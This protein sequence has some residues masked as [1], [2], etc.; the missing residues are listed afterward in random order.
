MSS[1]DRERY[2]WIKLRTDYFE[3]DNIKVLESMDKG[4]A[5]LIFYLK[6]LLKGANCEGML[7]LSDTIPYDARLLATVTNTDIDTVTNALSKLNSL[8]MI[9]LLDDKTLFLTQ[10]QGMIGSE[11][12]KAKRMKEYRSSKLLEEQ[13][14]SNEP[15]CSP[16]LD[17]E[18]EKDKDTDS[19][20]VPYPPKLEDI[21]AYV[22]KRK[23]KV[24][25][26][27][28]FEHYEPYGWKMM[29]KPITDWPELMKKWEARD[30][31][32]EDPPDLPG[33][34]RREK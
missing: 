7:R 4:F 34:V 27:D 15:V 13:A 30:G 21:E 5:Y 17:K 19:Y 32:Y 24:N 31:F 9:E 18:T 3:Q 16:E 8:G 23:S 2:Y 28:F 20:S 29:G 22:K 10:M 6:L 33:S 1:R 12:Y 14:G 11:T 26:K 25:A